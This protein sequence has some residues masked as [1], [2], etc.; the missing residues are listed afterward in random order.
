MSLKHFPLRQIQYIVFYMR[1][2]V[3][4]W[5]RWLMPPRI[6]TTPKPSA[7]WTTT[8][9]RLARGSGRQ[10]W[11]APS[12]LSAPASRP[13]Q[14]RGPPHLHLD[15]NSL[16]YQRPGQIR[17]RRWHH[18]VWRN[19]YFFHLSLADSCV[20]G[21]TNEMRCRRRPSPSGLTPTS[22]ECPAAYLTSTTTWGM[23]TCSPDCWRSSAASCWW[24]HP[25]KRSS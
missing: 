16:L 21:Q 11:P 12:C 10:R 14:V 4:C 15:F 7:N 6:W 2:V 9:D 8:T 13:W 5:A 18:Q 25:L 22:P 1:V 19:S 3:G 20:F 17:V 23:D 24:E